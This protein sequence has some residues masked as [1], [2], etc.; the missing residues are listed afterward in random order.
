MLSQQAYGFYHHSSQLLWSRFINISGCPGKIPA[1][2]HTEHLNR[3]AKEAIKNSGANNT[4]N[5]IARVG[6]PIG[7]IGPLLQHFDLL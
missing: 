6:Q 5:A 2:L 3:L 7:T 1:D 4:E